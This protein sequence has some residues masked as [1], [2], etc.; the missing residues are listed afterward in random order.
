MVSSFKKGFKT[1]LKLEKSLSNNSV[2]AYLGDLEKLY[3][4]I[5]I[6]HRNK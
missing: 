2:N 3:Q 1:F 6:T 5:E 4:F